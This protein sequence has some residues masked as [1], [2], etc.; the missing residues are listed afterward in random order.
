MSQGEFKN[1]DAG[2]KQTI[3]DDIAK[4]LKKHGLEDVP[5]TQAREMVYNA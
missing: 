4:V 2:T 5:I 1:Q 3:I